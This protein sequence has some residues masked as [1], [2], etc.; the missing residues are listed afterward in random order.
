MEG[1]W[2]MW[3]G[4]GGKRV[5]RMR[6]NRKMMKETEEEGWEEKRKK[7]DLLDLDIFL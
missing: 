1:D 6:R 2:M 3:S 4:D 5:R 7:G